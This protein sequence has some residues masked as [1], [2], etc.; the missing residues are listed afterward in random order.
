MREEVERDGFC[1]SNYQEMKFSAIVLFLVY[2]PGLYY[3][4]K[5]KV[6]MSFFVHF[7]FFL[8]IRVC[9]QFFAVGTVLS[10]SFQNK[11]TKKPQE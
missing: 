5:K 2:V 8:I 9:C 1:F 3:L 10:K 7:C 11:K 4:L 6:A